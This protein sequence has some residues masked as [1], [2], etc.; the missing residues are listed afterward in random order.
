[1]EKEEIIEGILY[2]LQGD[3][4]NFDGFGYTLEEVRTFLKFN[5]VGEFKE[6]GDLT[7]FLHEMEQDGLIE[8][9][10]FDFSGKDLGRIDYSIENIGIKKIEEIKKSLKVRGIKLEDKW[11]IA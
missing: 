4:S 3:N 7:D 6:N 1:M 8:E 2:L 9:R 5:K 11:K 10:H